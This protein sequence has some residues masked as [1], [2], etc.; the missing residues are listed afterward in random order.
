MADDIFKWIC[1]VSTRIFVQIKQEID[2]FNQSSIKAFGRALAEFGRPEVDTHT[3]R[4]G[5][6]TEH[7]FPETINLLHSNGDQTVTAINSNVPVGLIPYNVSTHMDVDFRIKVLPRGIK[8][9]SL[10]YHLIEMPA[11]RLLIFKSVSLLVQSWQL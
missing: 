2:L 9:T 6:L 3:F 5:T 4:N 8:Y 7:N 11:N 10:K 1:N